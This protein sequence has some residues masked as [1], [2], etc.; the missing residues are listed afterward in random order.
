MKNKAMSRVYVSGPYSA[1]NITGILANMKRGIEISAQLL[2]VGLAPFCPWLD[3]HYS[4]HVSGLTV[5]DY[6][7]YSL[8][9]LSVS[10]CLYVLNGWEKSKGTLAEIKLAKQLK[11]PI[12]YESETSLNQLGVYLGVIYGHLVKLSKNWG[13]VRVNGKLIKF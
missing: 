7:R 6:Y 9:W 12:Y 2:G 8:S 11:I 3:Y 13:K 5:E 4:L 1:N 10:H